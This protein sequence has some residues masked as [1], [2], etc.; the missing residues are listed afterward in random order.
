VVLRG[1]RAHDARLGSVGFDLRNEQARFLDI[2][3][4]Q[5]ARRLISSGG[6][7]RGRILSSF[8]MTGKRSVRLETTG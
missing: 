8:P 7:S 4:S 6:V 1:D 2:V 3:L 5:K